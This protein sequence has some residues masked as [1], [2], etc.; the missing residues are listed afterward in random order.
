MPNTPITAA[1]TGSTVQTLVANSFITVQGGGAAIGSLVFTIAGASSYTGHIGV[2]IAPDGTTL[3][4][5]PDSKFQASIGGS[6][7]IGAGATGTFSGPIPL[8]GV[9][10]IVGL[11]DFVGSASIP[12]ALPGIGALEY[13]GGASGDAV[14]ATIVAN[15][16]AASDQTFQVKITTTGTAVR[17]PNMAA[18]N[19]VVVTAGVS[20]TS[21]TSLS[22][23]VGAVVGPSGV[24]NAVDGTGSGYALQPGTGVGKGVTNAQDLYFNGIAGDVFFGS[25]N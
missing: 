11:S 4:R 18:T 2:Y 12:V 19:G 7:G 17:G 24:T 16:L 1:N 20:N 6:S 3:E 21:F 14:A 8:V 22:G 10:Y 25:V 5:L 9:V 23:A 13:P 15:A